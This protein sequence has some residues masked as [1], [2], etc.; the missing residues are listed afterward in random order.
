VLFNSAGTR[1]LTLSE[2]NVARVWHPS[3]REPLWELTHPST[4][5]DNYIEVAAGVL[6]IAA[7]HRL[8]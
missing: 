1:L 8:E 2:D 3:R 6:P 4:V 5:R 7:D